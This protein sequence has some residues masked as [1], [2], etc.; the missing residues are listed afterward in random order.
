MR[1]R[2]ILALS[3]WLRK[4]NTEDA[5]SLVEYALMIVLVAIAL[6]ASLSSFGGDM[7]AIFKT[8][9]SELSKIPPPPN[10]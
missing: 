6:T 2:S 8:I 10:G 5:Q 4:L 1:S 3:I 7:E 9:G